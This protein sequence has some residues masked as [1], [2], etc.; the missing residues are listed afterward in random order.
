MTD[1]GETWEGGDTT[2]CPGEANCDDWKAHGDETSHEIKE[3]KICNGCPMFS[4]KPSRGSDE[5]AEVDQAAV[6]QMVDDIAD[7]IFLANGGHETDWREYP[8]EIYRLFC[9]WRRAERA[10]AE[11]RERELNILVKSFFK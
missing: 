9:E 2:K 8:I 6:E 5:M 3:Q 10:I 7:M 11:R 1:A 4:S